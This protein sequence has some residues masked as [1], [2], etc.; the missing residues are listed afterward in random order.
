MRDCMAFGIAGNFANHLEQAGESGDFASVIS[1]E[2]GAPKG[3]F[4][5]YIPENYGYLG[6]FCIDSQKIILPKNTHFNV[7][8]EPEIALLCDVTYKK[9]CVSGLIPRYF[10]AFDDTSVRNDSNATKISQKKNFSLASKGYGEMIRIDKFAHGGVCD[11]FSLT[12]FLIY[13]GKIMQYGDNARL[14]SYSYFYEKLLN[15]LVR[16][17]NTQQDFAVLENLSALIAQAD[18]P[19]RFLISIG[20]T[21]YTSFAESRFL[22]ENDEICIV[23]YNHNIY[24]NEK[25]KELLMSGVTGLKNAS[26]VRQKVVREA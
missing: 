10:M 2:N 17:F 25:I 23:A 6:R 13:E 5:F 11:N 20:A 1:D 21:S 26:I 15:W 4:P 8:A 9:D 16:K 19:A 14:T 22:Q 18:Y 7:Q 24:N 12:S 3:V